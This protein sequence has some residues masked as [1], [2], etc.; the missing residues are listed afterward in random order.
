MKTTLII[1]VL[2]GITVA[3][4]SSKKT[5]AETVKAP[6]KVLSPELAEGKV[7]YENNCGKCHGLYN[8]SDF[9]KEQWVPIVNRMQRKAK[10][11]DAQRDLVFNYLV[12]DK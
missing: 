6:E 1:T 2:L 10:I 8:P 11:T 3:C 4:S 12:M 7:L 5:V 9:T